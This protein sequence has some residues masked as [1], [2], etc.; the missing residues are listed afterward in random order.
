M[1]I[2][3]KDIYY[4]KLYILYSLMGNDYHCGCSCTNNQSKDDKTDD[5]PK[6]RADYRKKAEAK[7]DDQKDTE[8]K[9]A[10]ED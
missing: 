7:E 3:I 6:T 5:E 4:I 9:E 8:D 10:K 2:K 1:V